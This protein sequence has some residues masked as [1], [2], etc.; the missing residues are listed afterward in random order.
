MLNPVYLL[1]AVVAGWGVQALLT[2][3][4]SQAFRRQAHALR[5]L[6]TV[7]VGVGGRRYRGGRAYVAL[8][9]DDDARVRGAL[10]LRGFTTF[11]RPVPLD[12]V[13]GRR[14]GRLAGTDDVPGLRDN[15]REACRQSAQLWKKARARQIPGAATP[16]TATTVPAP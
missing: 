7:S 11:S 1:V 10:V 12:A 14:A 5:E 6:G 3:R 4:Q 16:R 8:A 2:Y 15:E 9:F 13:V